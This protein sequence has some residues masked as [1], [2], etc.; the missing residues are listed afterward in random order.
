MV[1]YPKIPEASGFPAPILSHCL[2]FQKEKNQPGKVIAS[3][4][5][6]KGGGNPDKTG[7]KS[8]S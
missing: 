5:R 2:I 7:R 4:F 1:S 6:W 3:S 8:C